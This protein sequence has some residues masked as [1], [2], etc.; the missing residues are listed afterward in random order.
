MNTASSADTGAPKVRT[1]RTGPPMASGAPVKQPVAEGF[2]WATGHVSDWPESANC[3]SEPS[4]ASS[5]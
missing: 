4:C 5:R 2:R 3:S 1:R